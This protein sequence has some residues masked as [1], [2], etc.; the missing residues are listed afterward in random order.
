MKPEIVEGVKDLLEEPDGGPEG[1]DNKGATVDPEMA[2]ITPEKNRKEE[3]YNCLGNLDFFLDAFL[4]WA[5]ELAEN[6]GDYFPRDDEIIK[7]SPEEIRKYVRKVRFNIRVLQAII[8][9]SIEYENMEDPLAE[10]ELIDFYNES[11]K[12][13]RSINDLI[14][15][16]DSGQTGSRSSD[17]SYLDCLCGPGLDAMAEFGGE[18]FMN[19]QQKIIPRKREG[20]REIELLQM[21]ADRHFKRTD[22]S[23]EA[24]NGRQALKLNSAS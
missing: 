4:L 7:A 3:A 16:F 5:N 15:G 6:N 20:W 19:S 14:H 13:Y 12:L 24:D 2:E 9:A 8:D 17:H 1:N 23:T 21:I 11:L 10:Q 18:I 22:P